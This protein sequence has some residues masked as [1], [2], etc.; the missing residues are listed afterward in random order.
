MNWVFENNFQAGFTPF[1]SLLVFKDF[2]FF[3]YGDVSFTGRE[4]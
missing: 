2:A 3:L 4:S 1:S